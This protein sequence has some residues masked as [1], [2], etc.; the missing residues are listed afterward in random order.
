LTFAGVG[1]QPRTLYDPEKKELMPRAGF[2]Y[3]PNSRTVIRGGV[4]VFYGSLGIRLQDAI[5]TGF[6]Q[7]TNVVP[8]DDGGITFASSLSNPFPTGIL[9]ATGSSLGALTYV[10]NAI[11]FFNREPLAPRLVKYEVDLQRQ[12][13]GSFVFSAGYL[14]SRGSDLEVSRSFKPFP[15]QYLSTSP[16]RDQA[17][18]NYLTANLPNPFNGIPQFAG[19]ALSGSVL[20]RTALIAPYPQFSSISYFTSM[21]KAGTTLST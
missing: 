1:G 12:L 19:T 15:N 10:G 7:A 16:T 4:G 6:N 5:Q 21:A 11:S 2:A 13:P 3:A 14:G 17:T 8:S 9:Q 18:I 20:A